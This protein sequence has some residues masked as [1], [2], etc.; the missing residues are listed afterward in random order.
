MPFFL[1]YGWFAFGPGPGPKPMPPRPAP[2]IGTI[3]LL[4][5]TARFC[6]SRRPSALSSTTAIA[7]PPGPRRG[8]LSGPD[9]P[10]ESPRFRLGCGA[11]DGPERLAGPVGMG[12][13]GRLAVEEDELIALALAP[14]AEAS[15]G[16]DSAGRAGRYASWYDP[17][18]S[19]A[20]SSLMNVDESRRGPAVCQ[21]AG[22]DLVE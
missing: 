7:P 12:L 21:L 1:V 16:A 6:H 22:K 18:A 15:A 20:N 14:G 10:G 17:L 19:A 11:C 8:A 3:S 13:D 2:C 4:P 5:A 9:A